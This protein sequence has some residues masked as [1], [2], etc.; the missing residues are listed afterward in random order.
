MIPVF[1][2]LIVA[3]AVPFWMPSMPGAAKAGAASLSNGV[4]TAK[5]ESDTLI[6]QSPWRNGTIT[7][8]PWTIRFRDGSTFK[9][10]GGSMKSD[11][12]TAKATPRVA[13]RLKGDALSCTVRDPASGAEFVWSVSLLDGSNYIREELTIK[14]IRADVD[15]AEVELVSKA[16]SDDAEVVGKTPGSPILEDGWFYSMEHPMAKSEVKDKRARSWIVR[17]LPIRQGQSVTY[18]AVVGVTPV[19]QVRRGFNYYVERERARP[20]QPFLHY[21]SWYDLGYFTPF[22]EQ[23]C[24]ATIQ[25]W[26][27]E[28]ARKRGVKMDS[29]LFDDGWDDTST[30]WQFHKGFPNGFTPLLQA[31]KAIGA[32]PGVWLSPW[33]GYG[34]PR[35]QRL[36]TGKKA[37]MEVDGQGYALSGPRYY[38]RFRE[39]CI[40]MLRKYGINQFKFD[41]TGSPDKQVPGS[42][43]ASDFEAAINLIEELRTVNPKLFVNLTTGT[44][45]SPFWTRYADSIWRGGSDH[46][47]A[48]SGSNRQ[49]W[50]TYRD[51]DTYNGVVVKGPLYPI[52]SLMLHGLIYAKHADRL[53]TD[54]SNDF[55]DEVRAYFGTG[56]QLQEMY[57]TPALLSP[58]NWDDLAAAAKWSRQ[59]ADVLSDVHWVGGDPGRQEV[60]GHA[61]WN[62]KRGYLQLRNPSAQDQAFNVEIGDIL[63]MPDSIKGAMVATGAFPD[64]QGFKFEFPLDGSRVIS[65]KP[66]QVLTLEVVLK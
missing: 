54:P 42:A 3:P 18:S 5:F 39:V 35:K 44:W 55:R 4:V 57:I 58:Q 24:V 17:K 20:Y 1:A 19:G 40:E 34:N 38:A 32:G 13:S 16:S 31:A 10:P 46:S 52:D 51:A 12:V 33:G 26:G 22:N 29:F 9:F 62:G 41:G 37:G 50:I 63:E 2:V 49:K 43:F 25:K 11:S 59:M 15:V 56:T 61:G 23:E 14:P 36:E 47:F 48:G 66:F 30:V 60:Y 64:E 7:M 65:L 6:L 28:L 45:P 8:A 27:D 21:N 53:N